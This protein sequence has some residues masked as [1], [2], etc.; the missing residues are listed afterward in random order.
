MYLDLPISKKF[1]KPLSY[2]VLFWPPLCFHLPFWDQIQQCFC[3]FHSSSL[4]SSETI[5]SARLD[6]QSLA[7]SESVP[8]PL[9]ILKIPICFCSYAFLLQESSSK[10]SSNILHLASPNCRKI[11]LPKPWYPQSET[12]SLNVTCVGAA[13]KPEGDISNPFFL[14]T[15]CYDD[16][17]IKLTLVQIWRAQREAL[18]SPKEKVTVGHLC[19]SAS[20]RWR[21]E[22]NTHSFP[23]LW[24]G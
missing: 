12:L 17:T 20:E 10:R 4:W 1:K 3:P 14:L 22:E 11:I 9:P 21:W 6:S 5:S 24:T 19:G 8:C 7:S 15:P 18:K 13:M 2:T 16:T 23:W